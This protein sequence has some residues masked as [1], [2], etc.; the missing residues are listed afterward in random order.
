MTAMLIFCTFAEAIYDYCG[1][2]LTVTG[3]KATAGIFAT[4]PAPYLSLMAG[5]IDQVNWIK[6]LQLQITVICHILSEPLSLRCCFM[7]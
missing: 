3:A 7:Y 1:G 4:Y 6:V 5:F 2:N